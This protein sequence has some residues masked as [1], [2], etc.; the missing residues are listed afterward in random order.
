MLCAT[1]KTYQIALPL[2][3]AVAVIAVTAKRPARAAEPISQDAYDHCR[4][5][6]DDKARLR[7]FEGLTSPP[8][9]TAPPSALPA[10]L[11]PLDAPDAPQLPGFAAPTGPASQAIAGKWR[12]VHTPNPVEKHDVV[13]IMATA[14]LAESDVDFA[15]L[16]L[17]CARTDF[18]VLV[19]L[20]PPLPPRALPTVA[21][22]GKTFQGAVVS[23]GTAILLPKAASV[24]AKEQWRS[25]QSLSID[26]E[27]ERE[28]THGVV[29]LEG[30]DKALQS[31]TT[32]CL[33]R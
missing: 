25:L 17:R 4:A 24:L 5:I 11:D 23:P 12:L 22:N 33:T 27:A 14:E 21:I 10:P 19:F 29:S 9:Q 7:C 31:L 16:N 26:V 18:E 15:G 28:K 3:A 32:S 13:S 8:L 20:I 30:F 1:A 2:V 6:P